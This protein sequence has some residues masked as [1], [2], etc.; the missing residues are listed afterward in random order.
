MTVKTDMED[1]YGNYPLRV[2]GMKNLG[3]LHEY[4]YRNYWGSKFAIIFDE[5]KDEYEPFGKE[6]F[7]YFLDEIVEEVAIYADCEIRKKGQT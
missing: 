2:T 3:E 4:L 5:T 7:V 6:V 1:Q